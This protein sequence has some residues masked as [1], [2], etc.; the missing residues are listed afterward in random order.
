MAEN[1][2]KVVWREDGDCTV[3]ARVTARDATGEATG[4]PGEGLFLKQADLTSITYAVY[5][6]DSATP[7]T[8]TASGTVTIATSILDTPVM[9]SVLWTLDPYGYNFLH[10]IAA[11]AFA[12]GNH[13]YRAEYKFTTTGGKVGWAIYEGVAE[14]VMT[15]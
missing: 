4:S 6:L 3:L 12:T 13:R 11:T 5:D 7:G 14:A 2:I 10:D 8:P 1:T 15:S 9:T